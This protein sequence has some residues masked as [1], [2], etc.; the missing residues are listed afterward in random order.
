MGKR[1]YTR[2]YAFGTEILYYIAPVMISYCEQNDD[3]HT[4]SL[5]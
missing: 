4:Y 5:L 2:Y 3:L 1:D